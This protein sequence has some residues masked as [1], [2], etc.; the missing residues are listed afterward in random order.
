MD[1]TLILPTITSVAALQVI[2]RPEGIGPHTHTCHEL[3]YVVAGEYLVR[4]EAETW[5]GG[6]GH[7]F[8]YPPGTIHH[9]RMALDGTGRLLV[10]QWTEA[11]GLVGVRG[12]SHAEDRGGRICGL[13]TWMLDLTP[14]AGPDEEQRRGLLGALV[15]RE[16]GSLL[17]GGAWERDPVQRAKRV[18]AQ[19][20]PVRGYDI[21][22][23]AVAVGISARHL[24]RRFHEQTGLTPMQYLQRLRVHAAIQAIANTTHSLEHIA[25]EV[26][27]CDAAY[28]SRLVKQ[29]CGR[30][31]RE[32]RRHAPVA[33]SA[34]SEGTS[35][36]AMESSVSRGMGAWDRH[37]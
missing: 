26:G 10:L 28:L 34:S 25:A 23:L 22:D 33:P 12:P 14:P 21:G 35:A 11:E 37:A 3:V 24:G 1:T 16:F 5:H 7:L 30:S 2:P 18:M 27:I 4:R 13:L 19:I 31:P 15:L 20:Y 6:A 8:Y 29:A 17:E 36:S 32:M 9:G